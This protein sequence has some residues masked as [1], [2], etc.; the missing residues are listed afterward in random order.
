[1]NVGVDLCS[2]DA[3]NRKQLQNLLLNGDTGRLV[4]ISTDSSRWMYRSAGRHNDRELR[5]VAVTYAQ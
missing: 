1:M 3:V 4:D 5:V 2:T